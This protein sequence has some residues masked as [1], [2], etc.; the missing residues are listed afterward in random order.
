M[1]WDLTK[2]FTTQPDD[3]HAPPVSTFPKAPSLSKG[4]CIFIGDNLI[5]WKSKKQNVM[6]RYIDEA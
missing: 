3:N 6:A 1:L 5:S 4:Y 2:P